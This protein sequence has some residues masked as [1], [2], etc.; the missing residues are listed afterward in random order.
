MV[1]APD[2]RQAIDDE[3]QRR[4]LST[5]SWLRMTLTRLL[6]EENGHGAVV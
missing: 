2:L 3:A 5:S 1:V 6:A 4:G